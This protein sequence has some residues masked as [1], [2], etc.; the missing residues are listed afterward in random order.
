[1]LRIIKQIGSNNTM[2]VTAAH[3]FI[4]DISA[5]RHST[6]KQKKQNS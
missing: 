1:M 2:R 5:G 4:T 3:I 6:L